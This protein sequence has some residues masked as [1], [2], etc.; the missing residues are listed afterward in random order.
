MPPRYRSIVAT[1]PSSVVA[2]AMYIPSCRVTFSFRKKISHAMIKYSTQ[3]EPFHSPQAL[4]SAVL[5]GGSAETIST[6]FANVPYTENKT[7]EEI[8]RHYT[9]SFF[10]QSIFQHYRHHGHLSA[11]IDPLYDII[12]RYLRIVDD[13]NS[14]NFNL[15]FILIESQYRQKPF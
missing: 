12:P 10:I 8:Y 2:A 11:T 15:N 4:F 14:Q 1:Y 6:P 9:E 3:S 7:K 13:G 5:T